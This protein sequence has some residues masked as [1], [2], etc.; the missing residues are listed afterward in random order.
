MAAERII[1]MLLLAQR[2]IISDDSEKT[3]STAFGKVLPSNNTEA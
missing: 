1:A 2:F 3:T